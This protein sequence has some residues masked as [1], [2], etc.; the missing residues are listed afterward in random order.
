MSAQFKQFERCAN[1]E[2]HS[3]AVFSFSFTCLES[4]HIDF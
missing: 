3:Q 1:M 4:F 2:E